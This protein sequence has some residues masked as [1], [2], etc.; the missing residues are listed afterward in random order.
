MSVLMILMNITIFVVG[1]TLVVAY[2]DGND[3][4]DNN[5]TGGLYLLG[6]VYTII[7]VVDLI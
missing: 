2:I 6:V 1:G 7:H 5:A 4:Y 3:G